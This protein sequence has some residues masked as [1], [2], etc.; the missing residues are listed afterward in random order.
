LISDERRLIVVDYPS[1]TA[2]VGVIYGCN[3]Y[4]MFTH[5]SI[6]IISYVEYH[7]VEVRMNH[8]TNYCDV[9]K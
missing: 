7:L 5:E 4:W 8:E 1:Q 6:D 2:G 3:Q 9:G